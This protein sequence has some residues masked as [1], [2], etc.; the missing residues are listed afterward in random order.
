MLWA[1]D[2]EE[3]VE[4]ADCETTVRLSEGTHEVTMTVVDSFGLEDQVRMSLDVRDM[5]VVGLGDSFSAGS[6]NSRG[7]LVSLDYDNTR[8][9]RSGRSG[10]AVDFL[11]LT[12]GGNDVRFSEIVEQLVSEP[13]APV[14][15]LGG[16][17]VHDRS[18][19]MLLELREG[20]AR[21]AACFGEGF[22]GRPC[23]VEGPSGRKTT[24]GL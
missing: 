6:G 9:T 17:R 14:S 7:G 1:I 3:A 20:M 11:S 4:V 23:V 12:I 19:R 24:S 5:I 22:Q 21:V 2:G 16:E 10:Q 13:D 8:C 15:L 18:Q